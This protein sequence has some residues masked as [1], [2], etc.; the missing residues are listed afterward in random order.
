MSILC[1]AVSSMNR[2]DATTYS[3]QLASFFLKAL[4]YRTLHKEV[5]FFLLFL[6][7]DNEFLLQINLNDV[8]WVE[9]SVI[10]SYVAYIV[11][12][13][14]NNLRPMYLRVRAVSRALLFAVF[15][16]PFL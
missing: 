14:E 16:S 3:S 6:G 12:L 7:V 4:D 2:D 1:D 9:D 8:A 11:K 15:V 10:K 13:S 5:G